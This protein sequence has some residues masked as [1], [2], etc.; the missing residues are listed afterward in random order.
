MHFAVA[1]RSSRVDSSKAQVEHIAAAPASE[2]DVRLWV[3]ASR[4]LASVP[5]PALIAKGRDHI[6]QVDWIWPMRRKVGL[7]ENAP[8][9]MSCGKLKSNEGGFLN[10][11]SR[12]QRL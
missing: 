11:V 3:S 6:A 8:G 4:S 12:G 1:R 7:R 2:P 5:L 9:Q 10:S